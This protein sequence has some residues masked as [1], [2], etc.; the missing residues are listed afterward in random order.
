MTETDIRLSDYALSESKTTSFFVERQFP[1]I[2][3]EDGRELIELVK[4]YY[5]FMETQ[6][7]Q[8]I[9]NIRR[10]YDYRNIDTTLDR[11]L[12]F[13]KN[14]Y[15]NGLFLEQDTAFLVK[16]ILDLY[17]RKG[18][19]EGIELFFRMF[20]DAEVSVYYPSEDILKPSSSE[21]KVG[22][23]V[24][25]A[26]VSDVSIF[27]DITNKRIYGDKSRADGFVDAV[28]I[29]NANGV[30]IPVLFLSNVRGKFSGF[31]IIYSREPN[32]TYGRVYG[33][34]V[35]VDI[36]STAPSSPDNRIGDIVEIRSSSGY[37]AKGRV[38][39]VSEE[40]SGEIDF[41]VI[42]GGYGYTIDDT[43]ISISSQ[44]FFFADPDP[45]VEDDIVTFE[46]DE[47]LQQINSS[48][49]LV[50]AT[51]VGQ[52]S[53]SVGIQ[54]DLTTTEATEQ[55][56]TYFFDGTADISTVDRIDNVSI[57]PVFITELNQTAS[58]DIGTIS[59]SADITIVTDTIENFLDV[60]LD[61]DNYSDIPPAIV[62]MSGTRVNSVIPTL[63]TPINEAFVPEDFTIGSLESLSNVN[64][65]IDYF[66]DVFVLAK[67]QIMSRF[68]LRDQI[69]RI[70]PVA[71]VIIFVGDI[72]T[73]TK[74]ISDFDGNSVEVEVK[75]KVVNVEGSN[76]YVSQLTFESFIIDEPIFKQGSTSPITVIASTRDEN[77]QPL[78][79]N[80]R[81]D[82][83][84]ETV[85]GR[86]EQIEVTNS[87][88][89]Y[90]DQSTVEIYNLTKAE[91]ESTDLTVPDGYG[92][93][94]ARGQGIAEGRWSTFFS[95]INSNKVIQDSIFYQDYS[96]EI[97][98]EVSPTIYEEEY[99]ELLHPSGMKLFTKFAKTDIVNIDVTIP[100]VAIAE[101]DLTTG[102]QYISDTGSVVSDSGFQ[103][104]NE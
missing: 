65:G 49:T 89:V 17:R 86:I 54:L 18:S 95:H 11:M 83:I 52:R 25:L 10:I 82:G 21:W 70:V 2:Y 72:V 4:G 29:I 75:G 64:P 27:R 41:Q 97:S 9:Y 66:S 20:F 30:K 103:Y 88:F 67:E 51:V 24:Q 12:L 68:N 14:K 3:R 84:V 13:F 90:S 15:M 85:T 33:S 71:G 93:S 79:R 32:L 46:I 56:N 60:Q 47:R 100:Q 44:T 76:L 28:Y 7:N 94:S 92:T 91:R 102:N 39:R 96:Y 16:N 19:K 101:V 98:T 69:I 34:L 8:S 73:Q 5:E 74:T 61:S 37:G 23:F 80:A 22:S 87:G 63:S 62:E 31:D 59:D 99:R 1:E 53:T 36:D 104:L 57:T 26:G 78:G 40:L 81:I 38:T 42:S 58:A 48:N 55:A 43:S 45:E 77:S 50:T 35:S 6:D